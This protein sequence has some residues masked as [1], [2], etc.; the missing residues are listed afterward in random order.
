M[1][2]QELVVYL[3]QVELQELVVLVES[4]VTR[5]PQVCQELVV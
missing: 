1:D 3:V 2:Y 5:E 4:V